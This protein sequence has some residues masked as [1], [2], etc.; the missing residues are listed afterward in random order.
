MSSGS[1][2]TWAGRLSIRAYIALWMAATVASL[3]ALSAAWYVAKWRLDRMRERI[4]A[5][6]HALAAGRSLEIRLLAER[7]EDL[8]WRATGNGLHRA[9]RDTELGQ[10]EAIA[11]TLDEYATTRV[12]ERLVREIDARLRMFRAHCGADAGASLEAIKRDADALLG[13]VHRYVEQNRQDMEATEQSARQL[14][15]AIDRWS[16]ALGG[17]VAAVLAAGSVGLVSR[18]LRP[19]ME[20]TRAARQFGQGDLAARADVMRSDE[21]GRLCRTFNSMAEDIATQ[22]ERR[23]HF[24]A[25]VAHDIRGPLVTIGGA[26]RRLRKRSLEPERQAEW[27]DRIIAQTTRLERLTQDL[28]DTV[29]TATGRL[30]LNDGPLD[31]TAL[32]GDVCT[33]L[34]ATHAAHRIVFEGNE[35][36]CVVGDANRLE[37]VALNLLSNAIK[38]SSED[39]S[40]TVTVAPKGSQALLTIQD[41]GVGMSPEDMEVIFEPFGRGRGARDMA[42]GS[43]LGLY[44][45]R[46]IV[47]AH[48]GAIRVH[49]EPDV[50]TTVEVTLPLADGGRG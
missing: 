32:V 8:L 11:L 25:S 50:G 2:S 15:R 24:V 10:A 26:A 33:D 45:V 35:L 7:R 46:A 19:T 41:A 29:Q 5:D 18:V 36:C 1:K 49:T 31:I 48:G 44:I 14:G 3:V 4:V 30:T 37:R 16:L 21:L 28:M 6:A 40:V 22:E 12:E 47:E 23:L 9:Q 43:G 42:S 20:L 38:Y 13:A 39:T 34:A 17:F 27:L